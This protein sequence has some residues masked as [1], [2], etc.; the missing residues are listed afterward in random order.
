LAVVV[1]GGGVGE[2]VLGTVVRVPEPVDGIGD[3]FGGVG[4]VTAGEAAGASAGAGVAVGGAGD[5]GATG[6][7]D[8]GGGGATVAVGDVVPDPM[9]TAARSVL[10]CTSRGAALAD[11]V[12]QSRTSRTETAASPAA[13]ETGQQPNTCLRPVAAPGEGY[14]IT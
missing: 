5:F 11:A 7:G 2:E 8:G 3:P 13:I 9:A 10:S 1:G 14:A 12:A 4:I 6:A